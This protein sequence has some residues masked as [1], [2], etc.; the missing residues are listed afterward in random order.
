MA[1]C[2]YDQSVHGANVRN[3][4]GFEINWSKPGVGFGSATFVIK[5]GKLTC[6]DECMGLDFIKEVLNALAEMTELRK[7]E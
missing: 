7:E 2:V 4:G 6:D 1:L 3:E 5:D